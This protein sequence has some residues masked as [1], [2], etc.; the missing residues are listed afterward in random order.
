MIS[1]PSSHK[2]RL[3]TPRSLL[4]VS[5]TKVGIFIQHFY[6]RV[7]LQIPEFFQKPFNQV[8]IPF[9]IRRIVGEDVDG[10]EFEVTL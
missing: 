8:L 6:G 4:S 3:R 1:V 7:F 2:R 10:T 9:D 5:D